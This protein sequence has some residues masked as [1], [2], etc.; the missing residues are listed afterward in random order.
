MMSSPEN[1]TPC[2]RL[3]RE[4]VI[5]RRQLPHWQIGGS[6]YFITFRSR[7]GGLPPPALRQVCT[8]VLYDH[9]KRYDLIFGVVMPD[10]VHVIFQPRQ[11]KP[12]AWF[13]LAEIMKGLKGTSARRI[14]QLLGTQGTVWQDESYD[15]IIRDEQE[16][17]EKLLYMYNNPLKAGLVADPADYKFFVW[18]P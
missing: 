13:D 17:E 5:R 12:G 1:Q 15:R 3:T 16:L 7:R 6:V 9:G 11:R 14:N 18:P 4:L 10:H 2:F 8:H